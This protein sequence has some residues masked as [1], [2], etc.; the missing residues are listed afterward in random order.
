M[1]TPTSGRRLTTAA[2]GKRGK[3]HEFAMSEQGGCP[4]TLPCKLFLSSCLCCLLATGVQAQDG[5]SQAGL[6]HHP[7]QDQLLHE[8]FYSTWHMPNNPSVSCCNDAD[9]Y[10][11]EIQYVDGN[12]Y[13]NAEKTESTLLFHRKR[14]SGMETIRMAEITSALPRP[15]SSTHPIRG[16]ASH[17]GAPHEIRIGERQ[18]APPA[19][20]LCEVR[21]PDRSKLPTRNRHAPHLLQSQLLR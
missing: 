4:V 17:W 5:Q 18:D 13:A 15:M 14:S 2:A 9:C 6:H 20:L 10:P 12:I 1:V 11:T 19:S 21:S 7:P 16:S 3:F 8:K